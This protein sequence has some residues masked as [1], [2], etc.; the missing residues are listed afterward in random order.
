MSAYRL[1][2]DGLYVATLLH[3]VHT[4]FASLTR[5]ALMPLASLAGRASSQHVQPLPI[6]TARVRAMS[7]GEYRGVGSQITANPKPRPSPQP[8]F[9]QIP[10]HRS[11][12]V[13]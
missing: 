9:F 6:A 1:K 2:I 8:E 13:L 7:R 3:S 4:A 5:G 11:G 10:L 12:Y